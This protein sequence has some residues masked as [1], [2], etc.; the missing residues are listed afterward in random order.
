[1]GRFLK[2]LRNFT[3][4]LSLIILV[5]FSVPFAAIDGQSSK[6]TAQPQVQLEKFKKDVVHL[7]LRESSGIN[8][9]DGIFTGGPVEETAQL[10]SIVANAGR[11]KAEK[12]HSSAPQNH[13]QEKLSMALKNYYKI[14]LN[15]SVDMPALTSSLKSLSIV[16]TAYAEPTAAP[17]P[18]T[19]DLTTLQKHLK[20]APK[21]I[22]SNFAKTFPGGKGGRVR[23]IDIEYSWNTA[24]EDLSKTQTALV[25]NG[26]PADPFNDN[27]H[28]TAAIGEVSADV[29]TYGVSGAASGAS[30]VLINAYNTENGYDLVGAL[31]V[32]LGQAAPGDVV[33]IEQQTWGPTAGADNYVPVEWIPS[34]YDSIKV[35]TANGIN[36]VEAAGNG[37][38][39]L[40]DTYYYGSTF[41]MGKPDSGAIIVGAGVNCGATNR[42]SRL[43]FSTYGQRVNLQGPG[44]CVTTTGYGHL[45]SEGGANGFYTSYFSGTSSATAVVAAAVVSLSSAYKTLNNS[46]VL[47]PEQIRYNLKTNGTPQYLS[48]NTAQGHIGPYPNL[49]KSLLETD[50]TPPTIPANLGVTLNSSKQPVLTW[51]QATDR[52]QV[53][54]YRI[55]R[56]GR[57]YATV[58]QTTYT[59]TSVVLDT[60]YSYY[61]MAV[62]LS[63][64]RSAVSQT[65]SI[66]VQ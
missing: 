59:D 48:A 11:I 42:L 12:L 46:A 13:A 65:V 62:D 7:K 5:L 25:A 44:E 64:N 36:V 55:Y 53:K 61:I 43:G 23:V 39:N 17:S 66:T 15:K 22:D 6:V 28:G 35:L 47:T 57:Y 14:K 1:M 24:H 38:Q 49:A 33:F 58:K 10:N 40:D 16:E 26:T 19:A 2:A 20:A 60:R 27:N 4:I 56:D 54:S 8:L 52:V 63:G 41:P 31:N 37:G 29:N 30:V 3:S 34:V 51:E 18:V 45:S 32:A 9:V 21:G 50:Q